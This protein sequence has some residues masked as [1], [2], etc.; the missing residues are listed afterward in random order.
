MKKLILILFLLLSLSACGYSEPDSVFTVRAVGIHEKGIILKGDFTIKGEGET[1]S[2]ALADIKTK[3]SK[4]PSFEHCSVI[5]FDS[6]KGDKLSSALSFLRESGVP[7][8]TNIAYSEDLS[9]LFENEGIEELSSQLA[10]CKKTF[11]F[12]GNTALFEIETAIL[13]NGGNFALP[14]VNSSG[15][16]I[17]IE[18]LM[19]YEDKMPSKKLNIKQSR[20]YA[21]EVLNE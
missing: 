3:L 14:R 4:A 13:T 7:L 5:V 12:G 16:N 1:V 6:I 21:K 18:G 8:R 15:E 20:L 10:L 17:K 9:V 11:S 2:A 19:T